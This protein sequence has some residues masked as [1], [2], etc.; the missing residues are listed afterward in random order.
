MGS[1]GHALRSQRRTRISHRI[2]VPCCDLCGS[3]AGSSRRRRPMRSARRAAMSKTYHD[4]GSSRWQRPP[5][6]QSRFPDAQ[7]K[8]DP[9]SEKR[10][11]E[12]KGVVERKQ[13]EFGLCWLVVREGLSDYKAARSQSALP[14]QRVRYG[15]DPECGMSSYDCPRDAG[16]VLVARN[17]RP[18]WNM[19][20]S[21]IAF[22]R[23]VCSTSVGS[24]GSTATLCPAREYRHTTSRIPRLSTPPP[25]PSTR[26][27][28]HMCRLSPSGVCGHDT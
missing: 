19:S 16:R 5:R 13:E 26:I 23:P 27:G 3:D 18:L 28:T 25:Q 21:A 6:G 8:Q 24:E 4:H 20:N 15:W 9:P 22:R 14:R 11:L 17:G 10:R 1:R 2:L 12:E 7:V